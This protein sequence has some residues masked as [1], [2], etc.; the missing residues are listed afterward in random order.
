[1]EGEQN[2]SGGGGEERVRTHPEKNGKR[3]GENGKLLHTPS[4]LRARPPD[5]EGQSVT[6]ASNILPLRQG[7][8]HEVGRGYDNPDS[9][10]TT[11][12]TN[13]YKML[14]IDYN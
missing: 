4:A 6:I 10:Q 14:N 1:M 8:Y 9:T 5:S 13:N 3:K 7:E 11:T 12:Q 2:P